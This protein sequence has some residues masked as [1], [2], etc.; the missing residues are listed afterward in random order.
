MDRRGATVRR[1]RAVAAAGAGPALIVAA[2]L[3]VMRGYLAGRISSQH[4]DILAFWLPVYCHMGRSL[5]AGHIPAWNPAVMGGVPFAADPQ[6]GWMYLP[7]M[8]LF[9]ALPCGMAVGAMGV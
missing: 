7:V 3:V 2:V 5:A 1:W 6:S 9:S 8:A 4:P